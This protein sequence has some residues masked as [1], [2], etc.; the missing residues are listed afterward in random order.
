[1]VGITARDIT[2][3]VDKA[4]FGRRRVVIQ[5]HHGSSRLVI[6][7]VRGD[8]VCGTHWPH[9]LTSATHDVYARCDRCPPETRWILDLAKIREAL[10][11]PHNGVL[12]L[13]VKDVS[14]PP[15]VA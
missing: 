12:K 14:R 7:E 11:R 6:A 13:D 8:V 4:T 2:D 3:P 9:S 1:V 15:T 5:C 10:G